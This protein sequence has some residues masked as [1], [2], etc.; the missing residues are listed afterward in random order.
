MYAASILAG[1]DEASHP[2]AVNMYAILRNNLDTDFA[3]AWSESINNISHVYRTYDNV[4]MFSSFVKVSSRA[5]P[6]RLRTL[7]D[8]LENVK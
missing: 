3:V 5:W 6:T 8:D 4:R 2:E 1:T 7:I